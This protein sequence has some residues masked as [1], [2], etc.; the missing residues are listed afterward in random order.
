MIS[1]LRCTSNKTLIIPLGKIDYYNIKKGYSISYIR[2]C[3]GYYPV[4]G[5][6]GS[7]GLR[8]FA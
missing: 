6:D 1:V 4:T 8:Y 7:T 3:G 2:C 5:E